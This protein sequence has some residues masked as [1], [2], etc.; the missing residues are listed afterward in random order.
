MEI[1]STYG[2]EEVFSG[3]GEK[4]LKVIGLMHALK[5]KL[6]SS[7]MTGICCLS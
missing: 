1:Y 6:S 5:A 7:K 2:E 3:F 4:T